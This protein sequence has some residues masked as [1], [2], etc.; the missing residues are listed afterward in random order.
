MN[1]N[2][3]VNHKELREKINKAIEKNRAKLFPDVSA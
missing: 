1:I 3:F 2:F